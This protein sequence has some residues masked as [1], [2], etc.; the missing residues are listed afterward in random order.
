[1]ER[2][3]GTEKF[4]KP[5]ASE[6]LHTGN[7]TEIFGHFKLPDQVRL[8]NIKRTTCQTCVFING[9]GFFSIFVWGNLCYIHLKPNATFLYCIR[10]SYIFQCGISVQMLSG[11]TASFCIINFLLNP[12]ILFGVLHHN[13]GY[14]GKNTYINVSQA[15]SSSF[16][17]VKLSF[18]MGAKKLFSIVSFYL[19]LCLFHSHSLCLF[20]DLLHQLFNVVLHEFNLLVLTSVCFLQP[21]DA[22][23]QHSF[24]HLGEAVHHHHRWT[25]LILWR[26]I[27]RTAASCV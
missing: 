25:G 1:M 27:I 23:H 3:G 12:W 5:W 7:T 11:A 2:R 17:N 21:H 24:V 9:F 26:A 6:L 19:P 20:P 15:A 22:L 4:S 13:F 16:V 10:R 18:G 8:L 14:I